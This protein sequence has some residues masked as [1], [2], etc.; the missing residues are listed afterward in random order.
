M[1]DS[2]NFILQHTKE[3]KNIG[4]NYGISARAQI[5]KTKSVLEE[6]HFKRG[7]IL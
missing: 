5:R 2:I 1:N 4:E 7:G 6:C 3:R